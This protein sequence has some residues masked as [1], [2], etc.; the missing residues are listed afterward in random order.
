MM[1]TGHGVKHRSSSSEQVLSG[2]MTHRLDGPDS[3]AC[4]GS[5]ALAVS[6]TSTH[7]VHSV[8]GSHDRYDH[9]QSPPS[10]RLH[11]PGPPIV[12]SVH[13]KFGA[14]MAGPQ[15]SGVHPSQYVALE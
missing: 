13:R 9:P 3:P 15:T 4:G 2:P 8:T 1:S 11:G 10:P 5:H 7:P 12:P 14:P 6:P